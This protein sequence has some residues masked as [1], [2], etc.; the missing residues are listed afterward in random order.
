[1]RNVTLLLMHSSTKCLIY[2]S[3]MPSKCPFTLVSYRKYSRVMFQDFSP[4]FYNEFPN[5]S[6][7]MFYLFTQ[8]LVSGDYLLLGWR[9]NK[10]IGEITS[11]TVLPKYMNSVCEKVLYLT[12]MNIWKPLNIYAI[13]F[14]LIFFGRS[15]VIL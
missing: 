13:S 6:S 7:S 4:T 14:F 8:H 2:T 11:N 5:P 15:T 1:M 3:V 12:G 10:D 9:H